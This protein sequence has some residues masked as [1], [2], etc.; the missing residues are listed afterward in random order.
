MASGFRKLGAVDRRTFLTSLTLLGVTRK[1]RPPI[2]G[3]F[4]NDSHA[5]GHRL[6]DGL[7]LAAP[8]E[9]RRI[10]IAVVGGGIAGLSAAWRLRKRGMRDVVVLEMEPEAG[11]NARA[12]RTDVAAYPWAAHYVPVPGPHATLVRELFEELGVLSN[13]EWDERHLCHAPQERLFIHGRWQEGLEPAVGP[14]RRDRDQM[15]RFDERV[16]GLR[17]SG[18]FTIPMAIGAR[19]SA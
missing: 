7:I 14:S 3:G 16:R 6:R 10:A 2:T 17:A 12:G 11:G 19:P 4:V 1:A 18:E 5:L 15:A 8:R 13:G 9:T